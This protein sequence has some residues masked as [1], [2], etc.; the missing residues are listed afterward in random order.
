M[1]VLIALFQRAVA[2]H[3]E[4][5]GMGHTKRLGGGNADQLLKEKKQAEFDS[6]LS[7]I[8]KFYESQRNAALR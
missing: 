3:G 4:L 5:Q 2:L 7:E 6:V 8:W 1:D